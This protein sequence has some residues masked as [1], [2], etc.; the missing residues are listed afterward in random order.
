MN[1]CLMHIQNVEELCWIIEEVH[2]SSQKSK[3]SIKLMRVAITVD[4]ALVVHISLC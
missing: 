1:V 2:F 3:V 4:I